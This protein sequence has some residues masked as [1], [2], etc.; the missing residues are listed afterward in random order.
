[1][2]EIFRGAGFG[3]GFAIGFTGVF[4]VAGILARRGAA[5]YLTAALGEELTPETSQK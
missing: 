4:V 2:K 3:L 5:A 1:M